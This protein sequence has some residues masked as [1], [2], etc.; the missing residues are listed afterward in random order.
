MKDL[1]AHALV[2]VMGQGPQIVAA[3]VDLGPWQHFGPQV[4]ALV[5]HSGKQIAHLVAAFLNRKKCRTIIFYS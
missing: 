5:L 4:V 3:A 1:L 2:S